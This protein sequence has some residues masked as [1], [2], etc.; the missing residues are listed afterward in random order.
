[1]AIGRFGTRG[2]MY[3][4]T[5]RA[6]THFITGRRDIPTPATVHG[7]VAFDQK[8]YD[9]RGVFHFVFDDVRDAVAYVKQMGTSGEERVLRFTK[10]RIDPTTG[11]KVPADEQRF[12]AQGNEIQMQDLDDVTMQ[13]RFM[14]MD[15]DLGALHSRSP[16][17]GRPASSNTSPTP[18]CWSSLS[19]PTCIRR[20]TCSR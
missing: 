10:R 13:D 15:D 1:M 7:T 19:S 12:D 4:P 3:W 17:S 20:A 5:F 6:G 11:K 14:A 16:I 18:A 9:S 2:T 8:A